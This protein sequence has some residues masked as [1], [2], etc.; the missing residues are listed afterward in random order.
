MGLHPARGAAMKNTSWG[1][2]RIVIFPQIDI[3]PDERKAARQSSR[4]RRR[5]KTHRH[6][7]RKVSRPVRSLRGK[8]SPAIQGRAG[9]LRLATSAELFPFRSGNSLF[10]WNGR[11]LL[12]MPAR[13][14]RPRVYSIYKSLLL[15]CT[16]L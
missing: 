7:S 2:R 9:R 14:R 8:L 3:Q 13:I 12:P 4:R 11:Y 5:D 10:H 16:V 1:H 6:R 15:C